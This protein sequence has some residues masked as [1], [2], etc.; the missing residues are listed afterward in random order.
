MA[1]ISSWLLAQSSFDRT[2]ACSRLQLK[3]KKNRATRTLTSLKAAPV[4]DPKRHNTQPERSTNLHH[5]FYTSQT[6]VRDTDTRKERWRLPPCFY[7]EDKS[8]IPGGDNLSGEK[9]KNI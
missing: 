5:C 1:E 3:S 4:L 8:Q 6:F 2:L 9:R 7:C